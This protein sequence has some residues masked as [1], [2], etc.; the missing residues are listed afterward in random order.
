MDRFQQPERLIALRVHRAGTG[1][2]PPVQFQQPERLIALRADTY[3]ITRA[4]SI[5]FQQPER[6]IALRAAGQVHAS[7]GDLFQQPERLIALRGR[8]CRQPGRCGRV[9]TA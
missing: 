3:I 1:I 2:Q 4:E 7:Y 8:R 5:P 6:L 9:S